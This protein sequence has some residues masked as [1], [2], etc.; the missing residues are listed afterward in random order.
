MKR[1]LPAIKQYS[2]ILLACV[3]LASGV[4]FY[5]AKSIPPAFQ[6]SATILVQTGAPGTSIT[7][8]T[9]STDPTQSL[10]EA[11]TYASEIPAR[12][13]MIF[14]YNHDPAIAKRGFSSND[15]LNDDTAVASTT[16]ATVAVTA[17]ATTRDDAVF[18]ANH[19]ADGF[20][21]Y[22]QQQSQNS[23]DTLRKGLTD[24]LATYQQKQQ[25]L[26]AALVK[27][28]NTSDPNYIFTNNSLNGVNTTI[29]NLQ[30]QL[31]NLPMTVRSDVTV[32]QH[33][34]VGDAVSTSKTS[35]VVAATAAVGLLIG[36]L[37]MM[38]MIFL[39][40]RLRDEAQ[41]QAKL[42]I[43]YLGSVTTS[44]ALAGKPTQPTGESLAEIGNVYA[45]LRL[46]GLKSSQWQ[47][48]R[49]GV[50]LVTSVQEAE[51]KTTIA[52]ALAANVANAGGS[53]VVIDGNLRKPGTH[54][55]FNMGASSD[56]LS[57]ALRSSSGVDDVVKRSNIPGVWVMP[58]GM[59][60]SDPTILLEQ[61]L[62]PLLTQMRTKTDMIIIDGP[63]LLS[64]ADALLLA[65]LADCVVMVVDVR[66]DKMAFLV[67]AKE[68]LST[69]AK[70]P[71]GVI[72]NRA[73][74]RKRN[75]FYAT[76][77]VVNTVAAP[78][79]VVPTQNHNGNGHNGSNGQKS[80]PLV[81]DMPPVRTS[82]PPFGGVPLTPSGRVTPA[83]MLMEPPQLSPFAGGMQHPLSNPGNMLDLPLP[84][85][86]NQQTM[87]PAPARPS[88]APPSPSRIPPSPSRP[89]R[90][91]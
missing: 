85:V 37:I 3:V 89:G 16:A 60:I 12:E 44:R 33:A 5:I 70:I 58:A 22:S 79:T 56:G 26:Q 57:S 4:G 87:R 52:A 20:V 78:E 90:D 45:G 91:E 55:A 62:P 72:M 43:A 9:S 76:A 32:V 77:S 13:V 81:M 15:L 68:L 51:G 38:L 67:R 31:L 18:L 71:S 41:V 39:D 17:T 40:D 66:H 74:K 14:I 19:V 49:G 8:L 61:K 35:I 84:P 10:A 75:K 82:P 23:L 6:V 88:V 2:W 1:Y 50:L 65:T 53:V 54:I 64:N 36:I 27:I 80:E 48:P 21:V 47:A 29:N 24:Q 42:G 83:S 46:T 34:E 28:G 25:Q 73:P 30:S 7:T 86:N 69:L 63:A 11:N 59:P